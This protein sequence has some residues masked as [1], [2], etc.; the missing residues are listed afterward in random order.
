[1]TPG[2]DVLFY[3]VENGSQQEIGEITINFGDAPTAQDDPSIKTFFSD[4]IVVSSANGLSSNDF[5]GAPEAAITSFGGGDLGGTISSNAANASI[6]FDAISGNLQVNADGSFSLSGEP[7]TV[8]VFTFDYRLTNIHGESDATVT[9]TVDPHPS[10]V[11]DTAQINEDSPA[12]TIDVL[13]NDSDTNELSKIDSLTQPANGTVTITNNGVDLTYEPAEDYCNDG[14]PTDDF[15]YTLTPGGSTGSVAVTVDCVNDVP[16][17]TK[18]ADETVLEDAGEQTMAS[19]ASDISAGPANESGQTVSFNVTGNTATGLFEAGPAVGSSGTLTYTLAPNAN[20]SAT[21]TIEAQDDG[22]IADGGVDTSASQTFVINVTA[23]NSVPSFTK[24]ADETVLEDAGEQTRANWASDISAGPDDESGQTVSFNVTGNT[25]PGLFEAG[26]AVNSSGTLTYTLASDV[27]GSATITIEAQDDGGVA[28]GGVDTS[29]SQTFD[30]NVT[31]DLE[32]AVELGLASTF[33]V[34]AASTVTN[35]G[36]TIVGGDL[37]LNPGTAVTG[38]P[39][40]QIT[41]TME[42]SNSTAASAG[43]DA[44]SAYNDAKGRTNAVDITGADLGG[45]SVTPGVY[46][47]RTNFILS[48]GS[49]TLDGGGDSDAVF[50]FQVGTALVL[51]PASSIDLIGGAQAQNVFWQVGTEGTLGADSRFVGTL[52]ASQS[53]TVGTNSEIQGRLISLNAAVQLNSNRLTVE[54]PAE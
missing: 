6:A 39:P 29:A 14:S 20:G 33:A 44:L 8:G 28:D 15:T 2:T 5:R 16:S 24:G 23:V 46:K 53:I 48:A 18:G 7:F 42:I 30:I 11:D 49:F 13:D 17:F 9:L 25:E 38:F 10:A 37:G 12:T 32:P 43:N 1:M 36:S 27:N 54:P 21:I 35:T 51:N 40:G 52:M 45:Q 4:G 47:T 41:G 19:W 50:I 31:V 22:G 34:F 3:V 26:P